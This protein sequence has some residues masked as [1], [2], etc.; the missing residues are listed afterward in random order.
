MQDRIQDKI[1]G[2]LIGV[3]L[4]D[5]LGSPHEF[6]NLPYTGKLE[7]QTQRRSRW[8]PTKIEPPGQITDD[9]EMTLALTATIIN[10][11]SRDA[12]IL[13]YQRW[14]NSKC[15]SMGKNTRHLFSGVKTIKGYEKRFTTPPV[16]KKNYNGP[17][18]SQANGTLMRASPLVVLSLG[19]ALEDCRITNPHQ[20][21]VECSTIYYEMLRA[22][23]EDQDLTK[24]F[25]EICERSWHP[26]IAQ[27]LLEV[28]NGSPR[29]I[30][31][32][33]GWVVHALYVA[34]MVIT[35]LGSYFET[36][37]DCYRWIML[38]QGDT[39]TNAAIAGALLGCKLGYQQLHQEQ[40]ENIDIMM[41]VVADRPVEYHPK[42][43]GDIAS[44]LSGIY[45]Q[46]V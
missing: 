16:G 19:Q 26:D 3:A 1:H 30:T 8:Q 14:A 15:P 29:D 5:A 9:T 13:N 42:Q 10:G 41:N 45:Q 23:L 31:H 6:Q 43:I 17:Q 33:K 20:V 36:S 18:E 37:S 46:H 28:G 40:K 38:Q 44:R 27:M 22:T 32:N 24:N 35:R 39:D 21:N 7:H 2:M 12:A 4:G 11:Y 34:L 25:L